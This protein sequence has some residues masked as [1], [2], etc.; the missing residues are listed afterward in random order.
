MQ[1]Q[2]KITTVGSEAS[3]HL[4]GKRRA[5]DSEIVA[6]KYSKDKHV[7]HDAGRLINPLLFHDILYFNL[8]INLPEIARSPFMFFSCRLFHCHRGG[9]SGHGIE[10]K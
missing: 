2:Q 6:L 4:S 1:Q 3:V 5:F 9:D 7:L 10:G 8:R